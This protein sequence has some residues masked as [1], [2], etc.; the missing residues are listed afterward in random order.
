VSGAFSSSLPSSTV[1]RWRDVNAF[2]DKLDSQ[3]STSQPSLR[4][5]IQFLL[6]IDVIRAIHHQTALFTAFCDRS[7]GLVQ[8]WRWSCSIWSMTS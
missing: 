2:G 6:S 4:W 3:R 5:R 7:V 8:A 1:L